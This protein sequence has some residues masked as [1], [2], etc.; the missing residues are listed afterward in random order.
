MA[1]LPYDPY[2]EKWRKHFVDMA[3][4]KIKP[5]HMGRYIVAPLPHDYVKE[6]KEP[7]VEIQMV[8]PVAAAIERAKS[9]LKKKEF[10]K[11]PNEG[12]RQI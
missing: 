12:I 6:S 5:D 8:T 4:G 10:D 11:G 9:E 3:H 1:S 7:Q 2:I